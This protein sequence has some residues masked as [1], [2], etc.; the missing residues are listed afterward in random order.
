MTH[1]RSENVYNTGNNEDNMEKSASMEK[2]PKPV[3]YVESPNDDT[4][5]I[6]INVTVEHYRENAKSVTIVNWYDTTHERRMLADEISH[7]GDFFAFKRAEQ[8]GGGFYYFSPMNL[9]IYNDKVK[10]RLNTGGIFTNEED[11]IKAFLDSK[12]NDI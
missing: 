9:D 7:E 11:L 10:K 6:G 8:E 4:V 12:G 1:P 3:Y 2:L 5:L